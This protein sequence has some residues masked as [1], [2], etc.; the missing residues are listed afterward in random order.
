MPSGPATRVKSKVPLIGSSLAYMHDP[1]TLMRQLYARHGPVAPV[2]M[3]GRK[4]VFV[5]GPDA[6]GADGAAL[7][8]PGPRT[9]NG[10]LER[11]ENLATGNL[12]PTLNTN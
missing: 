12:E 6:C 2:P 4:T 10:N 3:L 1:L 8:T 5:F 7:P 9:P 11:T